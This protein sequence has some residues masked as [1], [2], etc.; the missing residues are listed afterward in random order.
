MSYSSK[1]LDII[2]EGINIRNFLTPYDE[3]LEHT[4][5]YWLVHSPKNPQT[6][7]Q[8]D[9]ISNSVVNGYK[10]VAKQFYSFT[11]TLQLIIIILH[12]EFLIQYNV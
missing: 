8:L 11:D 2:Q 10:S 1:H 12:G 7:T 6:K 9:S 4:D 5:D 3:I